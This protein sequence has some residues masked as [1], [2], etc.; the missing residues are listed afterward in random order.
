MNFS[1]LSYLPQMSGL[2]KSLILS[3][4]RPKYPPFSTLTSFFLS[5]F[6]VST[7]LV[8]ALSLVSWRGVNWNGHSTYLTSLKWASFVLHLIAA[9][10]KSSRQ[11]IP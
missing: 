2:T 8:L 6:P 3:P 5:S 10:I 11:M 4:I 1:V 9:S 7:R